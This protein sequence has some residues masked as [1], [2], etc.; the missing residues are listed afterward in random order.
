VVTLRN[1]I[2]LLVV[3]L[4]IWFIYSSV[5][6]EGEEK[7]KSA[8]SD[9]NVIFIV[10]DTLRADRLPFYGH[11]RD[12]APFLNS[13]AEKAVVFDHL[14]A[15]ASLTAPSTATLFTSLY[16][17]E[18]GVTTG[19][20]IT[21]RHRQREGDPTIALNRISGDITT[22]GELFFDAGYRTFGISDNLNIAEQ[23]GFAQGFE[24]FE[25]Y[26]YEGAEFIADRI[27]QWK[28]K[29]QGPE[30]QFLYLHFMD[31]HKRY[32]Q[33]EP[34]YGQYRAE[35]PESGE[36]QQTIDAYDSEINYMD[37][38][39]EKLFEEFAWLENSIVVFIS[40]HGE[41]FWEHG[42]NGHGSTLY[43]EVIHVPFFIYHPNLSHRRVRSAAH[44]ID[45]VPTLADLLNLGS[46]S[47]WHGTTLVPTFFGDESSLQNRLLFG[48]LVSREW[49]DRPNRR[50]VYL[51]GWHYISYHEDSVFE[52]LEEKLFYI[53]DDTAQQ[54]DLLSNEPELVEIMRN[55][56]DQ[57][58]TLAS[59]FGEH[60]SM[61]I[62]IDDDTFRTLSTLG[63][64]E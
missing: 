20:L 40:E 41:E 28:D 38:E 6:V 57:F 63:Y 21:R 29:L 54:N 37:R 58:I 19:Y 15:P 59:R 56:L 27:R 50:Y 11:T 44:L 1:G 43:N 48:E 24:H 35:N 60:E 34:W 32:R 39:I 16:P 42:H 36:Q 5:S 12:T 49:Q 4:A 17:S 23:M 33:R 14:Y 30:R 3:G 64:V 7:L 25:T 45:V 62:Q 26:R 10:A 13:L 61:S 2:L 55:Q 8:S 51:N 46:K 53:P 47:S 52:P 31:P 9:L 18:H 22:I